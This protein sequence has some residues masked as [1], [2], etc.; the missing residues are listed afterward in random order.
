MEREYWHGVPLQEVRTARFITLA[1]AFNTMRRLITNGK[2][3]VF[4]TDKDGA[5]I[6]NGK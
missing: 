3:H 2:E 6:L 5:V 1:G 4:T